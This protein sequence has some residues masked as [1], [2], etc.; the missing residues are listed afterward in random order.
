M[1]IEQAD[2]LEYTK[3]GEA[4]AVTS[5][6]DSELGSGEE[7]AIASKSLFCPALSASSVE[8]Q[9]LLLLALTEFL[10]PV[11]CFCLL[12]GSLFTEFRFFSLASSRILVL[13]GYK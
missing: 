1:E 11:F 7:E 13:R 5:A 3:N 8:E 12:G 2:D 9:L 6:A 4:A 10:F